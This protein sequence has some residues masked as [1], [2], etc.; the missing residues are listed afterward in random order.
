MVTSINIDL[1]WSY[2]RHDYYVGSDESPSTTVRMQEIRS[3]VIP[4]TIL[5]IDPASD[6]AGMGV[7]NFLSFMCSIETIYLNAADLALGEYY[8][9]YGEDGTFPLCPPRISNALMTSETAFSVAIPS[10]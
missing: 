1:F 2:S 10:S 8:V 9:I 3:I 7:H 4:E 6:I 5:S